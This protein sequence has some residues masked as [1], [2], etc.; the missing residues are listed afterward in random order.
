VGAAFSI[1]NKISVWVLHEEAGRRLVTGKLRYSFSTTGKPMLSM[2]LVLGLGVVVLLIDSSAP[3]PM[4]AQATDSPYTVG[5][6]PNPYLAGFA[7]ERQW[8]FA[9][10]H[11]RNR[12]VIQALAESQRLGKN[13]AIAPYEPG[14]GIAAA[15]LRL[16][17]GD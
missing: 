12:C 3:R 2:R 10:R 4:L 5:I 17:N 1:R 11:F 15:D 7:N 8:L 16:A 9:H 14:K 13:L 6:P